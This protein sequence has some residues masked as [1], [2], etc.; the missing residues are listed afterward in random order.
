MHKTILFKKMKSTRHSIANIVWE[1]KKNHHLLKLSRRK[2]NKRKQWQFGWWCG[3]RTNLRG[4]LPKRLMPGT[5]KCCMQF[6]NMRNNLYDVP[7]K[8]SMLLLYPFHRY[9]KIPENSVFVCVCMHCV[10]N[11]PKEVLNKLRSFFNAFVARQIYIEALH[12]CRQMSFIE[13]LFSSPS[14]T[15]STHIR[16]IR[17]SFINKVAV[18]VGCFQKPDFITL[19]PSVVAIWESESGWWLAR[20]KWKQLITIKINERYTENYF[21]HGFFIVGLSHRSPFQ[22]SRMERLQ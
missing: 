9:R 14:R 4:A 20:F 3:A 10:K 11:E 5:A 1:Y 21:E 15:K 18:S 13:I 8:V 12:H 22:V 19:E 6:D 16:E 7:F 2:R 17:I